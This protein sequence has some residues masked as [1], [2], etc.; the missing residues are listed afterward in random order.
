MPNDHKTDCFSLTEVKAISEIVH[1]INNR[2]AEAHSL[3]SL[4]DFS[5]SFLVDL[6][7]QVDFDKGNLMFYTFNSD[8]QA[9]EVT[10]FFQVGWDEDD[11]ESYI[12]QYCHIDDILPIL[13]LNQEIAFINGDIF[14]S[15]EQTQ[16]YREFIEPAHIVNSIDANILIP[17]NHQT[18]ALL[19]FFRNTGKTSFSQK[20]LEIIKVCQPYLSNAIS[21]YLDQSKKTDYDLMD[22]FTNIEA[23]SVCVLNDELK[24]MT[25]NLS[26]RKVASQIGPPS[27]VDS[28]LT[29]K[30]QELC[31]NLKKD[32][33]TKQF[34][35]YGPTSVI[36]NDQTY[37]IEI[38]YTKRDEGS[39]KYV[40]IILNDSYSLKLEK[41]RSTYSL[42]KRELEIINQILQKGLSIDEISSKL[43]ISSSTVKKHLTSTYQKIGVCNQKQLNSLFRKL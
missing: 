11:L 22:T 21:Q 43:Y 18:N 41:L 26:F 14:S 19:G 28:A 32:F 33:L 8:I 30:I 15:R 40:C 10:S 25:Y 5:T 36:V 29:R 27:V 9:Y 2:V 13:A 24:L 34:T 4:S 3:N 12:T 23:I 16:Y 1:N 17:E 31:T 6:S 20:D 42:S 38:V 37:I 7:K 35:K 39:G